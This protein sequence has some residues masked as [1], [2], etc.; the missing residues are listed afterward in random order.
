MARSNVNGISDI[1]TAAGASRSSAMRADGCV[2]QRGKGCA[3][4]MSE[5][6]SPLC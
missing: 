1:I 2:G 6:E 3:C 5:E 4:H